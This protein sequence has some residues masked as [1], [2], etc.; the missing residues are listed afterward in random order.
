[1]PGKLGLI[2][3]WPSHLSLLRLVRQWGFNLGTLAYYTSPMREHI[4]YGG[5]YGGEI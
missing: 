4:F 2:G 5:Y 1:M 3:L